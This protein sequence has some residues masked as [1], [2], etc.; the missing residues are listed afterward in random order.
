MAVWQIMKSGEPTN[1][2]LYDDTGSAVP[3][4]ADFSTSAVAAH[5]QS[6]GAAADGFN[7]VGLSPSAGG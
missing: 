6:L 4:D 2:P 5:V 3:G 7:Y 1:A